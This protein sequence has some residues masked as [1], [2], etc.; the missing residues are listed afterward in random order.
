VYE[1]E[2]NKIRALRGYMPMDVLLHQLGD[3]PSPE[4]SVEPSH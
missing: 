3:A 4:Q 2:G 1:L